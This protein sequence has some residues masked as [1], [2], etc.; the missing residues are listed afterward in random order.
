MS[1]SYHKHEK[2]TTN[3]AIPCSR[4]CLLCQVPVEVEWAVPEALA[5]VPVAL[6]ALMAA[7]V[8]LMAAPVAL[9]EVPAAVLE[10]QALVG[11]GLGDLP[12]G[13]PA[14]GGRT[15][16]TATVVSAASRLC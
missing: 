3:I 13:R 4:R 15:V 8:A 9:T 6:V 1:L 11:Q 12:P 16:T 14:G 7:P 10:A 5:E 2:I